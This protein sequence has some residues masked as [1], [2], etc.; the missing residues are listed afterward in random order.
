MRGQ[1]RARKRSDL[2]ADEIKSWVVQGRLGSGDRLPPEHE[3]ISRLRASKGTVREAL[4]S[5]EVQGMVRILRGA[6]GGAE[7][8]AVSRDRAIG[9]LC[10]H[11]YFHTPSIGEVY[12][13]RR[14]VEPEMAA[15]TVGHL[16]ETALAELERI[17]AET[18]GQPS[19]AEKR[20]QLRTDELLFHDI[21]AAA[22]PDVL[23][24]FVSQ[25]INRLLRDIVVLRKIYLAPET[26]FRSDNHRSHREI[27]EALRRGERDAVRQ[28]MA[29]HMEEAER[30]MIR[31]GGV[32][33]RVNLLHTL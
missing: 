30:H 33:E 32:V 28:L 4:K 18:R 26:R 7:I 25:L 22:C 1:Q 27:V 8:A 2:I 20:R 10:N 5:L 11:L 16:D 23:L 21:I 24:G 15:A 9:L 19:S 31:L 17:I 6:A 3:L 29:E 13:L 14:L 12:R